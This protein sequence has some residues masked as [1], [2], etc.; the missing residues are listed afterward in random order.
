MVMT[1]KV[2]IL[3]GAMGT[4]LQKSGMKIGQIPEILNIENPQMIIDI[5]RKYV[6]SGAEIIYVNTFGA[7]GKKLKDGSLKEVIV[8]ALQNGKTAA[9]GTEV[10]VALD[11][12]PLGEMLEP[13]GT[14]KF[15]EAYELFKE[16]ILAGKDLADLVVIETMTDLYEVRAA[17][18]A[19][20]ENS[21]LPVFVTMSF[22]EDERTFAGVS[23][24]SYANSIAG[25]GVSAIGMNCS[26]GP[27]EM[28][29]MAK[30]MCEITDVDIIIKPN[31]GLPNMDGSYDLSVEDFVDAMERIYNLGVKYLG[32]CCGTNEEYIK[33]LSDRLKGK[34]VIK[35]VVTPLHGPSSSTKFVENNKLIVVGERL[36]PTGK[37]RFQQALADEEMSYFISQA[38]EQVD[39]GAAVLD[40]NVGYPG[41]EESVMQTKIIK[42]LQSVLDTPI[43]IDST[44]EAALEAGIRVYNGKAIVNSVNGEKEKLDAVLPL[45]KKYN[46]QVI[47]L[48]LDED[49][50]PETA[51][52]RLNIARKIVEA[53]DSYGIPREDIYIDC[54]ALTVSSQPEAAMETLKAL[55]MIKKELGV[56]TALGV[57]NISFGLPNRELINQSFLTMAMYAGLDLAII[58]PNS[59]SMMDSVYAYRLL[60]NEDVGATEFIEKYSNVQK[61]D[62]SIVSDFD[63]MTAISKGLEADVREKVKTL[64]ETMTELEVVDKELIP[65]LDR[66]GDEYEKGNI[67]LPQLIK[68]ANA[69][70]AGFE[71]IKNKII[72]S[73]KE[74]ISK[75][76]I[77][78]ATV[79]GDIH[80]IGKN[81]AKVILENYGYNVLDL[82]K[83]VPIEEVVRVAKEKNIKLVG[84]SAL[85]TTTLDNMKATIVELRK[86]LPDVTI[87]V[88][89]AVLTEDYSKVID[90]NYYLKDA[91]VNIEVARKIF[92][93]DID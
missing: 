91:K 47:G 4:M 21:D 82:G 84:L 8:A 50:I 67:F 19:V 68:S 45:V 93:G 6:D 56:K 3:D 58:N 15:E 74:S 2:V 62:V 18:L 16:I 37:K 13:M 36:N 73:G 59:Q 70:Q 75:G 69:A 9:A 72:N 44:K 40:L 35:R 10:K 52:G 88:G 81:I 63:I 80:D 61:K 85:M 23:I 60:N 34:E 77:V 46:A 87:M 92:G 76:D 5:H 71:V 89:G 1:N 26:L 27:V 17:V 49:G 20:T 42:A 41:I 31:A 11:L 24:E 53:A 86:E 30:Q 66:V 38:I 39:A 57:S 12:G 14:L 55:T 28:Y 90:A 79:K 54:L 65:A 32:G 83:D 25:L 78:V 43:Q 48:A 33:A 64:L 7:N 51:E 22:E 29:D